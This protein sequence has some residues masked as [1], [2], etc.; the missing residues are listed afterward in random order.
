MKRMFCVCVSVVL[1]LSLTA[2]MAPGNA[3]GSNKEVAETESVTTTTTV[4]RAEIAKTKLQEIY[5]QYRSKFSSTG[6]VKLE[7]DGWSLSIDTRR[8]EYLV[9]K[10]SEYFKYIKEIN[11]YLSLPSSINTKMERTRALDGVLSETCDEYEVT[12]CYHPDNGLEIIYEV[13]R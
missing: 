12:W 8:S 5:D 11:E 13:I 3:D 4:D 6:S 2:C 10:T 1:C 7:S 9:D